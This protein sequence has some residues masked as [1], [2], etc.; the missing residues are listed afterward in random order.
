MGA[1][2]RLCVDAGPIEN[3]HRTR[4]IGTSTRDLLRAMTPALAEA[5]GAELIVTS[6][7]PVSSAARWAR[8]GWT[9]EL[10]GVR[11]GT[12]PRTANWSQLIDGEWTLP[13][14]VAATGADVFL[15]T[16]PQAVPLSHAFRTVAMLYD[17][18]PLV[19]PSVYLTGRMAGLPDWLFRH[20][21]D[22]IRRAT[23]QIAISETARADAVRLAGF[24]ADHI[25]VVPL[26]V[27]HEVFRPRD[28]VEARARLGLARPYLLFL[29]AADPRKNLA[30]ML[31]AY[32]AL[33]ST[34]IDL[35]VVGP[36]GAAQDGVRW[37]GVVSDGDLP[38]LYAGALA[39]VFPSLYEGFGLPVLEAMASGTPV[40]TSRTSAI[41]EVAGDAACYFNPDQTWGLKNA[42]EQVLADP[43]LR[44]TMRQ[45]GLQQAQ[46]YSWTRTAAG[47]LDACRAVANNRPGWRATSRGS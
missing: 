21:L 33:G 15:A 19:M 7:E 42:L 30:G 18:V 31:A 3:G 20:R 28:P 5:H 4:G 47:V 25:S 45:R 27:D 34:D 38:C 11:P 37:L 35:V 2:F 23:A 36:T 6:R 39:F 43:G 40:I 24:D 8:R 16:D 41:P 29:G 26:A 10:T 13:R 44:R 14:D 9:A 22:R 46:G 1:E 32:A 12:A 17:V